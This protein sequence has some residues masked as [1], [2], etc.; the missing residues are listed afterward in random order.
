MESDKGTLWPFKTCV[1]LG[2]TGFAWCILG[3]VFIFLLQSCSFVTLRDRLPFE[4]V[5]GLKWDTLSCD[6]DYFHVWSKYLLPVTICNTNRTKPKIFLKNGHEDTGRK[7]TGQADLVLS[8][9]LKLLTASI[10]PLK[11][12]NSP[13]AEQASVKWWGSCG[14]SQMLQ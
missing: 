13:P 7:A 9:S 1:F 10:S 2:H 3:S 14:W 4:R 8:V 6:R 5:Q 11:G 12:L